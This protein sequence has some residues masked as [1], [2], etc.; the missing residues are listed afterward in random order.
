MR[1]ALIATVAAGLVAVAPVF[2]RSNAAADGQLVGSVGPGFTISVKD[3]NGNTV[4]H[5]DPG[6][7]TLVVHDLSAEHNFD[8]AGPGVHVATDIVATGDTTFTINLTDGVYNFDCDAHPLTMKGAF[9]VGTATLPPPPPPPPPAPAPSRRTATLRVAK[10][11][12]AP[13]RLTRGRYALTVEDATAT[14]DL[15]LKGPGVDRKTGVSFKG[16]VS[17][18]VTLKAG[19]YRAYSDAHRTTITRTITVR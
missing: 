19:T 14:D 4:T 9:A 18:N 12:T 13:A 16:K 5:L 1:I 6:T 15:H 7:Y 2:G 17:W 10:T 8:L 11:I 3:A